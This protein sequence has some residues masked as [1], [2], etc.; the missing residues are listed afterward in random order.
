MYKGNNK[1][2]N[3]RPLVTI[4]FHWLLLSEL[5]TV[6]F[7]YFHFFSYF[8]FHFQF[9]SYFELKVRVLYDIIPVSVISFID[10]GLFISQNKFF[11]IS[12]SNLFC[13][14]CVMCLLLE[15]FRLVIEHWKTEVLHF[16]RS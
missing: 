15:Q 2:Q 7:I 5:K 10:D 12:N 3:I 6:D 14:H 8:H 9:F 11:H 4:K 1:L 13:S 16:S